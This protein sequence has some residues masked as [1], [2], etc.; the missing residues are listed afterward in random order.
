MK[1]HRDDSTSLILTIIFLLLI[2]PNIILSGYVTS[3]L[4]DWF[5]VP[6]FNL[7]HLTIAQA[8]GLGV[9]VSYL[10]SSGID[11]AKRDEKDTWANLG[12][13][14]GILF[15]PLIYLFVGWIYT[16]FL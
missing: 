6:L 1:L 12:F 2:V 14:F 3:V 4:W 7:P 8:L 13:A 9:C 16:L 10:N 15:R 11:H 5:I